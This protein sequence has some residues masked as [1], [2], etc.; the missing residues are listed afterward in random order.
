M[1]D[2]DDDIIH[3][4][5]PDNTVGLSSSEAAS[6]LEVHGRNILPERV[7]DN[8]LRAIVR[9]DDRWQEIDAALLVPGDK[10]KLCAGAGDCSVVPADCTVNV[11]GEEPAQIEVDES[12]I[13]QSC[14]PATMILAGHLAKMG[15]RVLRG[16][17]DATVQFTGASTVL[18]KKMAAVAAPVSPAGSISTG[19][20]VADL[21]RRRDRLE[22]LIENC[23]DREER[24]SMRHQVAAYTNEIAARLTLAQ[25]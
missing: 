2:D 9:R 8:P 4:A 12:F 15:S 24:I 19:S 10:V 1:A 11:G 17:V 20:K 22:Q 25:S 13:V 5:Y 18:G 21:E 14:V 16:E 6:R 23:C 7:S 3:R